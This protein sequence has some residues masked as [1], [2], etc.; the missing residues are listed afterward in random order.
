VADIPPGEYDLSVPGGTL[1]Y[2]VSGQGPVCITLSGGPGLDTRHLESLGGITDCVTLVMLHP[3]GSGGSRFPDTSDWSLSAFAGDVEA[4]RQRLGVERPLILGHSHGGFIALRYA[5]EYP[6]HAGAL[7]LL[8]TSGRGMLEWDAAAALKPYANEPWFPG[9]AAAAATDLTPESTPEEAQAFF[10][11]IFPLY[12]ARLTPEARAY[13]ARMRDLAFNPAA[14]VHG[15]AV[16]GVTID[17]RPN[18]PAV[19]AP[20]LVVAG[21]HDFVQNVGRAEELARLLP[22]AEL[23]I[24]ED[25]GHF[26]WVEEQARFH[27]TF[28]AFVRRLPPGTLA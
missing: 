10:Q 15:H 6:T 4:L 25:S 1:H 22:N 26:S 23:V 9:A 14:S 21:R 7:A 28:S 5:I 11:A 19:I 18:L 27:E 16:N 8:H 13:M 20:A 24:F 2:T 3:R 12:F 17:Q